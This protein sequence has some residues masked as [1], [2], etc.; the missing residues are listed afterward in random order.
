MPG[1]N[2][3]T[4]RGI[5]NDW[6]VRYESRYF[7]LERTSDYPPRQAKVTG[8]EWEDERIETRYRGQAR[9]HRESAGGDPAGGKA[10]APVALEAAG[11][12]S[13]AEG[14]GSGPRH[15]KGNWL[16]NGKRGHF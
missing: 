15:G 9:E 11:Q 5:S 6:V 12:P 8:C 14:G 1:S 2:L 13:V 4:E 10:A 3:E 7:Q 16:R